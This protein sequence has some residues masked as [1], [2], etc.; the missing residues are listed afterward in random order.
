MGQAQGLGP[1]C[2]VL[3]LILPRTSCHLS[4]PAPRPIGGC[5]W[6]AGHCRRV[7]VLCPY[8]EHPVPMTPGTCHQPQGSP[9]QT[10]ALRAAEGPENA[11][12]PVGGGSDLPE[13]VLSSNSSCWVLC[14]VPH[15][16]CLREDPSAH[17]DF[18]ACP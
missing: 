8:Q 10:G 4:S 11:F 2:R 15:H 17:L 14:Q 5:E 16:V 6:T 7:S 13:L 3:S 18:P 12:C 9:L 1:Q